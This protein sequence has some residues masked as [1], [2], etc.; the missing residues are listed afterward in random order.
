MALKD[1][2]MTLEDF[3]A[4]RDV[5]VASNSAQ[6]TE[7]RA[8]I[9]VSSSGMTDAI[10]EALLACFEH[11]AWVDASGAD[12]Y[13]DLQDALYEGSEPVKTYYTKWSTS[14]PDD[15]Y[16]KLYVRSGIAILEDYGSN[17]RNQP[18]VGYDNNRSA[19]FTDQNHSDYRIPAGSYTGNDVFGIELPPRTTGFTATFGNSRGTCLY[20]FKK[21]ENGYYILVNQYVQW[22]TNTEVITGLD[23]AS[24]YIIGGGSKVTS[25]M[26]VTITT[27]QA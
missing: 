16:G 15:T 11:V 3:K 20:V 27:T 10:K 21:N 13:N 12:A 23:P 8:D 19:I 2:L 25:Q 7:L 5:D 4:V 17:P 6:F 22:Y 24:E 26:S 18:T 9:G 14:P 1:K